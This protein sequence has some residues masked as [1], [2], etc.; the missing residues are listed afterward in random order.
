MQNTASFAIPLSKLFKLL[1]VIIFSSI[2]N[3]HK[4]KYCKELQSLNIFSKEVTLEK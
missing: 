3:E 2:S 4:F 1:L